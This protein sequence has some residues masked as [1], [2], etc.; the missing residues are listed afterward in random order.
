MTD[1]TA[2]AAWYPAAVGAY[3]A[4]VEWNERTGAGARDLVDLAGSVA[5]AV[6]I[7]VIASFLARRLSRERD[8]RAIVALVVVC[9]AALFRSYADSFAHWLFESAAEYATH[10]P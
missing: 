6:L 1:G 7:A 4:I 5:A 9:W 10:K 3:L 2:R 8:R